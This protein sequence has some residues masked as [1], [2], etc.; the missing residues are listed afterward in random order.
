MSQGV[1]KVI[2]VGNV[3]IEPEM[4]T[5]TNGTSVCNFSL[6]TNS[7]RK[8]EDGEYHDFAEFHRIVAWQKLAEICSEYL[9]KGKQI[10]IEGR[11]QTRQWEKDGQ[12]HY[13]TE[14]VASNMV[15]LG[16]KDEA[17]VEAEGHVLDPKVLKGDSEDGDI[18]F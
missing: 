8:G 1:N 15:M 5:T 3:S 13:T 16:R 9:T 12:K 11:L 4:R 18:P 2:L 6:A 14:V 7:K 17:R 10:Y